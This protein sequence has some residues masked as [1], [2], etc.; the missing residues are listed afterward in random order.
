MRGATLNAPANGFTSRFQSTRP[1]RGA[2]G[3][4]LCV[5]LTVII[6]IH[7]PLAGRDSAKDLHSVFL[8]HFNPR[9]P[10]GARLKWAI[11]ELGLYDISIHAPLAGR[12]TFD[13]NFCDISQCHFNPRAPCGARPATTAAMQTA[14]RFQSTR[15][16]RGATLV[17][18]PILGNVHISIHAPLAGCDGRPDRQDHRRGHFNPRTPCGVR[19][20]GAGE[21]LTAPAISIHAPLAGCDGD[22][23]TS[24]CCWRKFQ[25]THPLRGAT[26]AGLLGPQR[27]R[28]FNPRTPCGVRHGVVSKGFVSSA[29][30]STH[31]LRGAT[32]TTPVAYTSLRHFNPRTPCGVRRIASWHCVQR[33]TFQSTHPLRGAT[34]SGK[35]PLPV[36]GISIHA[37]LAG[38]DAA[39][40][41]Q[42]TGYLISIHAPLAGCDGGTA[43]CMWWNYISIHAPLA[44]CD[45]K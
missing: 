45:H 26:A 38:C 16:L 22:C 41:A 34:G 39:E 35:A 5:V 14:G 21:R 33:D 17:D 4:K 11:N 7:A 37:P 12:D 29:F 43:A 6:S 44:G 13:G 28:H 31:P 40:K 36:P 19:R 9:A 3:R 42:E 32:C 27:V 2:T 30:Q 23:R 24:C 15:P 25:S 1:L 18:A 10:C 8:D 20:D